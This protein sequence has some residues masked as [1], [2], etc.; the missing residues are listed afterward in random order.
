MSD[1]GAPAD[2]LRD[3]WSLSID[4]DAALADLNDARGMLQQCR[5]HLERKTGQSLAADHL[6]REP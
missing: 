3:I 6:R 1:P 4:P 2:V 5:E